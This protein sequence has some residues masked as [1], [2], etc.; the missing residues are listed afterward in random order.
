MTGT[1]SSATVRHSVSSQKAKRSAI[2]P[3]PRATTTTSTS[4]DGG[5]V[6]QGA[7]DGRRGMAVLHGGEGPHHPPRPAA[8]AQAGEHVVAR[9]AALAGHHADAARQH[10]A[11]QALLGL[12]QPFGSE[13]AAQDLDLGEQ[14]ALAREAQAADGE[15]ERGRGRA[16]PRVV[17][18]AAGDDHLSAVGQRARRAGAAPR[19]RRAT[20][21]RAR[22]PPRR[23]ART[24]RERAR[25]AGRRPRR[26]A[27]RGRACAAR[28]AAWPRR[29]RQGTAP[30]AGS[31]RC[32]RGARA[33]RPLADNASGP[34]G[35]SSGA[36][37]GMGGGR[38]NL[39]DGTSRAPRG[40]RRAAHRPARGHAAR[41]QRAGP[42]RA[43]ARD[44]RRRQR[45]HG[46][47]DRRH[48]ALPP[49]L[50]RLPRR[51]RPR[52]ARGP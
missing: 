31:R 28:R 14:V 10:G 48:L 46:L 21:S 41:A 11:R 42:R 26:T 2:D 23:A 29:R 52:L 47:P 15:R 40:H 51:D 13:R 33:D 35:A 34:R 36:S 7:R 1:R 38:S 4:C 6:L 39:A 27:A 25:R 45:G 30:R 32:P 9:L 50:E 20:S 8:A 44:R 5:Q 16:R 24:T 18:G 17:V 49:G 37:V 22:R 3:P 43:A 12:E 19:R